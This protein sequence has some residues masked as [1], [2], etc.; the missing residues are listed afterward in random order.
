MHLVT[1]SNSVAI[2]NNL[3]MPMGPVQ[4][5]PM[6]SPT[7]R[8]RK[9]LVAD[10]T[11]FRYRTREALPEMPPDHVQYNASLVDLNMYFSL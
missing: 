1:E 5:C 8:L 6:T 3:V 4:W 2:I 10:G 11:L 9:A 7:A